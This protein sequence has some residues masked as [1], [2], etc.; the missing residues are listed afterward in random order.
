MNRLILFSILFLCFSTYA[1]EKCL[2]I[3]L[4]DQ[5][6]EL[7][8]VLLKFDDKKNS[9]AQI[10]FVLNKKEKA[11]NSF[12]C[13]HNKGVVTC[14]GDDNSGTLVL[15]KGMAKIKFLAIHKEKNDDYLEIKEIKEWLG[16]TKIDCSKKF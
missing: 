1:K 4:A 2:S 10:R 9:Q 12:F 8:K 15:N 5:K 6:L 16:A 13:A 11:G 14:T 3:S 7:E